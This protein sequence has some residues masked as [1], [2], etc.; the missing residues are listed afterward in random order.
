MQLYGQLNR[1]E[2]VRHAFEELTQ[3][4]KARD[5]R[6]DAPTVQAYRRSLEVGF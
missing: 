1:I 4:L 3:A 6:P 5:T 2:A